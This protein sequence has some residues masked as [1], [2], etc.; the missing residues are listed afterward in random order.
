MCVAHRRRLQNMIS[1]T[2]NDNLRI[3]N[4]DGLVDSAETQPPA[5]IGSNDFEELI[6]YQLRMDKKSQIFTSKVFPLTVAEDFV[7]HS[8]LL[9][10]IVADTTGDVIKLQLDLGVERSDCRTVKQMMAKYRFGTVWQLINPDFHMENRDKNT[11]YLRYE[12]F[13]EYF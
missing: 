9:E 10:A 12:Y 11:M 1:D 5:N 6:L 4:E 3:S 2:A 13:I 8:G 7:Y